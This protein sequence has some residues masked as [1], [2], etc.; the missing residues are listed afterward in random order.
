M[1]ETV[2]LRKIAEY[3]KRNIK[4]GYTSDALKWALINQ[5]YQRFS[6]EKGIEL[7][8][9]EMAKEAPV[10]REKPVITHEIIDET[11]QAVEVKKQWWKRIFGL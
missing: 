4:K 10:L 11:G 5:G 1:G 6:V 3:Y 9:Q 2:H 8:N 7:A